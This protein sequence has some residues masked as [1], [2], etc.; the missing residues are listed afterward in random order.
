ME[1]PRRTVH[2]VEQGDEIVIVSLVCE[3]IV[4]SIFS[5][6]MGHHGNSADA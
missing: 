6:T 2:F 3:D 5:S 1:V 4:R